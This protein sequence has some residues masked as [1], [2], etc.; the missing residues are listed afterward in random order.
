VISSLTWRSFPQP[1]ISSLKYGASSVLRM[2]GGEGPA[3][4][5]E[6]H[7]QCK[8]YGLWRHEDSKSVIYLL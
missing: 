6:E 8:T 3:R 5:T 1:L 2:N 7:G 4:I